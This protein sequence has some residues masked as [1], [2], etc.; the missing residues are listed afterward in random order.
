[1]RNP[2]ATRPWQH[3]LEPLSGYLWLAAVLAGHGKKQL[4]SPDACSAF[5]FGPGPEADRSVAELVEELLKHLPGRWA[6]KRNPGAVHEAH[7][8]QLC[9]DKA[10]IQLKW[11]PVWQFSEAVAQTAGWYRM[12]Q[13]INDPGQVN[14]FT[15][16]QIEAYCA[17]AQKKQ[18]LW[19]LET[20]IAPQENSRRP[21]NLPA[22]AA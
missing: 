8:L 19:A 14:V 22:Y 9:T 20:E 17:H 5:N 11:T 15:R 4:K 21:E 16:S 3:V 6:D 10:R 12:A 1:V 2:E 18:L 13:R 7:L